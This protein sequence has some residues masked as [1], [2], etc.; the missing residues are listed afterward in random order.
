VS[1]VNPALLR[2]I[3]LALVAV[4]RVASADVLTPALR[5]IVKLVR[6]A[7][8][9]VE[10]LLRAG[11]RVGE[12]CEDCGQPVRNIEHPLRPGVVMATSCACPAI[13]RYA[14]SQARGHSYVSTACHHDLHEQCRRTC[15][16]CSTPCLCSCHD[17]SVE[18]SSRPHIGGPT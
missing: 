8:R 1:L 13:V 12:I 9:D 5:E 2:S 3:R 15:K 17:A 18:P 11:C 6:D 7:R 14:E 4:E 10:A 16:F